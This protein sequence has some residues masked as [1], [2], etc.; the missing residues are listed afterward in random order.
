M[1]SGLHRAGSSTVT[2]RRG[3]GAWK[4]EEAGDASV[5]DAM[6]RGFPCPL[7][8]LTG[9]RGVEESSPMVVIWAPG[10]EGLWRPAEEGIVKGSKG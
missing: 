8:R 6:E 4:L 3:V 1:D 2:E 7:W 9:R 5:P 10:G